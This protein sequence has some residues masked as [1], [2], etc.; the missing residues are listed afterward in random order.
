MTS[1]GTTSVTES[2][3]YEKLRRF[4]QTHLLQYW[5][6]LSGAEQARLAEQLGEVD[7]ALMQRLFEHGSVCDA[8]AELAARAVAPPAFRLG[9]SN[10]IAPADARRQGATALRAGRVGAILVAG[11]QG[12]R[13]GFEHPKGMFPVGPLSNA[14]LFQM[15]LEKVLAVG[16]RYGVRLPIYLMTSPATHRETVDFLA[17][18]ERFGLASEE[19]FIFCQ[20][21]MPAVDAHS[22]RL[23]LANKGELFTSPNGHGGMLAALDRSGA[24]DDIHH[25]GIE[26]L[27]YFQVDNPL[28]N[29]ADETFLGYHLLSGS[30]LSTQVVPK[31]SPLDKVG[32]VVSVDGQV[33]VIEYSDLPSEAA[34]RRRDD[35]SLELWAGNIAVHLFDVAFLERMRND[36]QRLPFH[37]ARKAVPCLNEHG[38]LI[39]PTTP[40]AIKYERFIFDL[41]PAAQRPIV[42]E[43]DPVTTFAPVKNASGADRD[44]PETVRA[45]LLALHRAWLEAV[46]ATVEPGVAV[47]ISPRYAVD[48]DTLRQRVKP[49]A[50]FTR[51]T[52]LTREA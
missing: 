14:T 6:E 43:V 5:D 7:F 52:Y 51:D 29:V 49:G 1:L 24:L 3:L 18:N 47:E 37:I 2:A 45:Q 13:L 44:T 36:E 35:G 26:Q 10:S 33:R 28:V 42:V 46:G 50:H 22:G 38:K 48:V 17:V 25:R 40:N 34:H 9:S 20:G 41:L 27:F 16:E 19:L 31:Q 23:L 11:G 15:L 4:G 39:E 30:E 21:T 12:T 32:N 8:P